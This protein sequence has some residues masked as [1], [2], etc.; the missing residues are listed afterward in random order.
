MRRDMNAFWVSDLGVVDVA[1]LMDGWDF[2]SNRHGG[3]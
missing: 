1:I 3:C 2:W